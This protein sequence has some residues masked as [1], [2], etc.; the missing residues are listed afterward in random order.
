MSVLQLFMSANRICVILKAYS[1]Q[2]EYQGYQTNLFCI[3]PDLD[4]KVK[5]TEHFIVVAVSLWNNLS[6]LLIFF[7]HHC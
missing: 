6:N 5:V 3:L 4:A 1:L 2:L 7:A